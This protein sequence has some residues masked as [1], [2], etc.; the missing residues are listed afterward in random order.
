MYVIGVMGVVHML[1]TLGVHYTVLIMGI[2]QVRRAWF[3][4]A[5]LEFSA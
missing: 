5:W 4:E 3:G 2:V 1:S